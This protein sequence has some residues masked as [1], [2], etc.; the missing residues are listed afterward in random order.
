MVASSI[1]SYELDIKYREFRLEV[2]PFTLQ[3]IPSPNQE[4]DSLQFANHNL[5]TCLEYFDSPIC[6]NLLPSS[7]YKLFIFPISLSITEVP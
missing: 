3:I 6:P 4:E 2:V 1:Q 7:T 5:N